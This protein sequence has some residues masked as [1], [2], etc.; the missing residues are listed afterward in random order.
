VSKILNFLFTHNKIT[1][2]FFI[3]FSTLFSYF[4]WTMAQNHYQTINQAKFEIRADESVKRIEAHM[5]R[6]GDVL[7]TGVSFIQASDNISAQHWYEFVNGLKVETNYPGM[8][9]FGF[10][11]MF[12]PHELA[13]LEQKMRAQGNE[14]F[15]LKPAGVREQ[16]SAILYLDPLNKRN[17]QAIGYDMYSNPTRKAAMDIARDSGK[18]A[19]SGKVTLVQEIDIHKQAGVLLY[20]PLYQKDTDINSLQERRKGLIG[21][22]YAPFRMD[23]L[24]NNTGAHTEDVDFKIYDGSDIS[25]DT[26]MYDS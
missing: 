16:Y 12:K 17:Q 4:A 1:I 13:S 11:M 6:D 22:V 3:L 18:P 24:L 7:A 21:F 5:L 26:L 20:T 9:G 10:T 8:Q 15:A 19:L 23:D 2:T 25:D 14:T